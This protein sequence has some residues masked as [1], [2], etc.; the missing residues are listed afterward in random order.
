MMTSPSFNPASA[1]GDFGVTSPTSPTV[2]S[3]RLNDFDFIRAVHDVV[4]GEDVAVFTD[5]DARAEGF[6]AAFARNAFIRA[7]KE[8]FHDGL[9]FNSATRRAAAAGSPP[10]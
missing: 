9:L 6:F 8:H 3:G 10:Q 5:N 2:F 1:A 7:A 4:V